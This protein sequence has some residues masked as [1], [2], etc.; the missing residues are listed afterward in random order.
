MRI[1][2]LGAGATGGYFGGRLAEAGADVT[3]L[4]RPARAATIAA[5]GLRIRSPE[6]DADIRV[7]TVTA[8]DQLD[9]AAD[10]VLLSCKA[11]DLD[12]A[13]AAITGAVGPNTTIL[14]VLNGLQHFERL[15]GAFGA[16]R[17]LGGLCHI[18][19][20]LAPDGTVLHTNRAHT[21]TF[22][23]R[24]GGTSARAEAI[25]AACA[26]ALFPSRL[27]HEVTQDLWEKYAFLAA[28]AS[29]TCLMRAPVGPILATRD[30]EAILRELFAE[31]GR[32][33]EAFGH[34]LRGRA[35]DSGLAVLTARG[36]A[37][38]ASMMRDLK[39]GGRIEADPIIGDLLRR[40]ESKGIAAPLLRV[41]FCHL[42][43]YQ[44]LRD[45]QAKAPS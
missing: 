39:A 22:G 36:S 18:G 20:T 6:G 23:E 42:Q 16:A 43:T 7:A 35:I 8:A 30:G 34:P 44:E 45:E 9:G 33:A 11:Y 14:P 13:I 31:C 10:L 17:V 3:F 37:N 5:E 32:V 41:A 15:D 4:L 19:A 25:A 29:A 21:L 38:S 27:S 26:P 24:G 12:A 1:L 40:A 28:L 2:V